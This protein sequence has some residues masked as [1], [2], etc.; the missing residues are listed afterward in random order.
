[1]GGEGLSTVRGVDHDCACPDRS[2]DIDIDQDILGIPDS[3]DLVE[4][5]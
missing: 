2:P 1:M 4:G 5:E 3:R